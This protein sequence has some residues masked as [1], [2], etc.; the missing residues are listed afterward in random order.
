MGRRRRG[1]GG[2]V[3]FVMVVKGLCVGWEGLGLGGG[4][5]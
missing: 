1:V 5:R 4:E 2:L 3:G